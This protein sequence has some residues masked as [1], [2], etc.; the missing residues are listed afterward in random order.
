MASIVVCGAGA[1]GASVAYHLALAGARGVVLCDRG[2]IAGGATGKAFGGVRQQFSTAAEVQL[3][4]ESLQFFEGLGEPLFQQVGYLFLALSEEGLAA[5]EERRRAQE[6]LDV[7]VEAVSGDDVA[8]R[9][10]GVAAGDVFGGVFGPADGVSDPPAVTRE[11][12]RRAVRLG[13]EVREH[14]DAREVPGGVRVIACGPWSG[15]VAAAYGVE[16]PIRPLRRQLI[17]TSPVDDLSERL[18]VVIESETGFHFRRRDRGLL[19]AMADTTARWGSEETVDT[20][21]LP[22]RLERLARRLP[23]ATGASVERAWAGLYDM[24]PDAHPIIDRP[25][26]EL[27]IACGFSGH[28]FMQSPAVGKA[29]AE[30]VL[31]GGTSLDVSPYR[32]ARFSE[33]GVSPEHVVL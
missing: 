2:E 33:G 26:D 13:V 18:P 11:L 19:L 3:A 8:A 31:E 12:V 9:F 4:K 23:A 21:V 32:L 30:L 5:L 29:A 14:T 22:D 20:T 10:P 24:T 16:L 6:E 1:V 27:V 25:S 7:R 28:G 15:E 17:L